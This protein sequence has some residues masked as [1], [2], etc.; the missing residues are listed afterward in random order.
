MPILEK[1]III[2][3][4]HEFSGIKFFIIFATLAHVKKILLKVSHCLSIVTLSR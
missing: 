1:K 2:L 3:T 4:F